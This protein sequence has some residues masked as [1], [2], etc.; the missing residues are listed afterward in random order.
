MRLATAASVVISI[1]R[2]Q[3]QPN[4]SARAL[5]ILRSVQGPTLAQPGCLACRV[6]E[7][8]EPDHGILYCESWSNLGAFQEHVQSRL[9]AR[10]LTTLELSAQAPEV[11]IHHVSKTEGMELIRALRGT[12]PS[13]A[14]N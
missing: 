7:E 10:L 13:A 14:N 1:I 5:E 8:G 9:Y 2:I 6:A 4:L 11:C 12:L 3:P